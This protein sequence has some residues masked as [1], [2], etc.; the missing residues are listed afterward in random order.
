MK[1]DEKLNFFVLT[2]SKPINQR[3]LIYVINVNVLVHQLKTRSI[4]S[5][6]T[7]SWIISRRCLRQKR[8][9]N[10]SRPLQVFYSI[11]D[12]SYT[13]D[14]EKKSENVIHRT[15]LQRVYPKLFFF[16]QGDRMCQVGQAGCW[17]ASDCGITDDV[18]KHIFSIDLYLF[19]FT[20]ND[21]KSLVG[22]QMEG[23]V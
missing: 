22:I 14:N 19:S 23:L 2:G 17:S 4:F 11:W 3:N 5:T 15:M 20:F 16:F 8:K 7:L 1:N 21:F 12:I 10:P 6:R 9:L 13:R 18:C